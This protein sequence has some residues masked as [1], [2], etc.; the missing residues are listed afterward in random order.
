MHNWNSKL[1]ISHGVVLPV[2]NVPT[3]VCPPSTTASNA[4]AKVNSTRISSP[5]WPIGRNFSHNVPNT[6]DT[7]GIQNVAF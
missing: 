3:V 2:T 5:I 7:I 4:A 1:V 6:P